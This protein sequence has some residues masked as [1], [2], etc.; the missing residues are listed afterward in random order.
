MRK[1][2]ELWLQYA[3]DNLK[4]ARVLLEI[5]VRVR[6]DLKVVLDLP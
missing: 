1:D 4:S 3:D 6:C 2:T 5:A